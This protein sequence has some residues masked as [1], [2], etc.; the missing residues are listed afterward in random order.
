MESR[1]I[2]KGWKM[3]IQEKEKLMMQK[4][5]GMVLGAQPL[6][7]LKAVAARTKME[8]SPL[9]AAGPVHSWREGG[10]QEWVLR[11]L[12]AGRLRVGRMKVPHLTAAI[13]PMK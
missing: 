11:C 5:E 6:K 4:E 7:R 8:G 3:L 10:C 9:R 2:F 12:Q 1:R 13:F